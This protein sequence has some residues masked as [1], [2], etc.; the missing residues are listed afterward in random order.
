M[1]SRLTVI[2]DSTERNALRLLARQEYR[3][4]HQQA[5]MI[6]RDELIRRGLLQ[7]EPLPII[8]ALSADD[9]QQTKK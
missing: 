5:A 4:I 6:I 8:V 7:N 3:E 2:L 1:Q 9:P